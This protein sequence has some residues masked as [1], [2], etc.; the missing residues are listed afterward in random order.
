MPDALRR[1]LR[2]FFQAALGMIVVQGVALAA[3]AN[4]GSLDASLWRRAGVTALVAGFIAVVTWAHNWLE[5]KGA[6]P[7]VL[8]AVASSGADPVTHDP[9]V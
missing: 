1:G 2:T 3:D 7:A 4:D 5:D 8:K 6:V 9:A